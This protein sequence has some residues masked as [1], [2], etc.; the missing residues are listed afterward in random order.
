MTA[1]IL[2]SR[3]S[4]V[5]EKVIQKTLR[6]MLLRVRGKD[7]EFQP[8]PKRTLFVTYFLSQIAKLEAAE[9]GAAISTITPYFG[10]PTSRQ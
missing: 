5:V 9:G 4:N 1:T 8:P 6:H 10:P 2:L 3:H 7:R